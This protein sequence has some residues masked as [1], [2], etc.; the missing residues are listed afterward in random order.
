MQDVED[1][2]HRRRN[3]SSITFYASVLPRK[4]Y[5][6]VNPVDPTK[7]ASLFCSKL[8]DRGR[9]QEATAELVSLHGSWHGALLRVPRETNRL[10]DR[11]LGVKDLSSLAKRIRIVEDGFTV[12]GNHV[13][14]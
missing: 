7:F 13:P 12:T 10:E 8:I 2:T 1:W 6:D 3:D 14:L 5:R 9:V 11:G 4:D